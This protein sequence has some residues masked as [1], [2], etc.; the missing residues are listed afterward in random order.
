MK[1]T[2]ILFGLLLVMAYTAFAEQRGI[3]MDFHS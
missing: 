1:R 3:F 2:I